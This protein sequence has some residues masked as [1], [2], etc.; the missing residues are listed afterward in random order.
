V[1]KMFMLTLAFIMP[2]AFAACYS[3]TQGSTTVYPRTTA[4]TIPESTSIFSTSTPSTVLSTVRSKPSTTEK[5]TLSEK[6]WVKQNKKIPENL[7]ELMI[8]AKDIKLLS[9]EDLHGEMSGGTPMDDISYYF[10]YCYYFGYG[11]FWTL[12]NSDEEFSEWLHTVPHLEEFY[13]NGSIKETPLIS[14]IQY[15]QI[16]KEVFA[17]EIEKFRKIDLSDPDPDPDS[18]FNPSGEW[19]EYPNLDILYTFD[20]EIINEYYKREQ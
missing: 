5:T 10:R 12:V 13:P 16:P 9:H 20:N 7:S 17:A 18:L 8:E 19:M 4:I 15:F 2:V 3:D 11:Q 6:E 14:F 1:K